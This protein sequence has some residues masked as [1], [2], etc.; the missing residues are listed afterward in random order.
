MPSNNYILKNI[1]NLNMTS[2][3]IEEI[4]YIGSFPE[5]KFS[6]QENFYEYNFKFQEK[7]YCIDIDLIYEA[8]KYN[9]K[10]NVRK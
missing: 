1:I 9:E 4:M 10:I 8:N 2:N 6:L 7:D 3:K 5:E